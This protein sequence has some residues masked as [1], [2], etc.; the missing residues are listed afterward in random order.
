MNRIC[1]KFS[2]CL[3]VA[4]ATLLPA[5]LPAAASEGVVPPSA[6]DLAAA[7]RVAGQPNAI[8]LARSN[9][10]QVDHLEPRQITMADK[11]F[12]VYALNPD[13]VRGIAGAPAGVLRSVAVTATAD[14]GQKATLQAMLESQ[15]TWVAASVFSGNDEETLSA[16]LRPGSV[17]LNEPQING[18]Y[19]LG[20]DG[21][22]LLQA[23]LPQSPVGE[24]V[25]L[26]EYQR[27]VHGR[28]A[29]KLPGSDYQ[30]NRGIGFAQTGS[31]PAESGLP[32]AAVACLI[33]AGAIVV[34]AAVF[35][36]RRKRRLTPR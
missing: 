25:P 9:F 33:A 6:D 1:R 22:V 28:Y 8:G 16:R 24:F 13:F 21:V 10:R 31:A 14:S 29:D 17:L 12:P 36:V 3:V 7:V 35:V 30:R 5:T 2:G 27:A 32:V 4:V 15:G 11:G 34:G 19:E 20:P 26:S 23:S 18:W